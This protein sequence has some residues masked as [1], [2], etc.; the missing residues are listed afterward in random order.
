MRALRAFWMRLRGFFGSSRRAA[1]IAAELESHLQFHIEDNLRAGMSPEEARRQAIIRLGG[2]EQ[3]AQSCRERSTLPWLETV[4]QDLRFAVRQLK[5][6]PGFTLVVIVTL[7][8][9]IGVNTALFSIVNTVLLHPISLPHPAELVAVDASKPN[10]PYGSISWPNFRDWSRDNRSFS[11]L[12]IYKHAGFVL[13]GAGEAERIHGE[14]VSSDLF[15]LLGVRPTLG[16]L[17]APGEDEI[18]RGPLVLIGEGFWAR[19]F[20]SRA[21]IL[22]HA[23][24]LDG[25]TFTIIGVIPAAFDLSFRTFEAEDVYLPVGQWQ[26]K[27]LNDR[28]AGL[29]IH[30][31]ARLRPGV[32]L[33]RAQE[34]MNA[35][36]SQLAA[37]YPEDDRDIR[38][39]LTPLRQ[40]VVGDVQP[41]LLVLLG[42]VGFVLLIACVNVANLLLA[43][44]TARAQ[45][46]AVRMALG[47]RRS[48]MIRQLLTESLLLALAGG[49]LGLL[50][51]ASGTQA[52]LRL[53]PSALPHSSQIHLSPIV[54]GF[55]FF[56]S[57][58]V[59]IFFGLM[60]AWRVSAQQPQITLR[61]GARGTFG[62]H[63]RAQDWLVIFEIAAALVLLA[64][65][66]LMIRS[67]LALSHSDPGFER[68]GVLD[69]S[70][71]VP[72]SPAT[73]TPEAA[74]AYYR[75]VDRQIER[76]PGVF[77][78]SICWDAVP[79]TGDDDE[80]LFWLPNEVKPSSSMEMHWALR[81]VVEPDYLSVMRIPLLRGRFFTEADREGGPAVAVIDEDLAH[82]YFG[83]ANPIGQVLNLDDEQKPRVT[84]VGVVRHIMQWEL[85]DDAGF[86][87]RAQIYMPL[88][89]E[90]GWH[91]VSSTGM[92]T[93]I[94]VRAK[95]AA[96]I[97][98]AIQSALRRMNA[99]QVPYGAQTMNQ[100]IAATLSARRFSMILLGIFAGLA[101]LLA[102]VGLYGV[103]SYLVGQRRQEIAVRMALGADRN[104][105]LLWVVGRGARLSAIGSLAGLAAAL[106]LTRLMATASMLSGSM[107]Y[108]V[109]SWDPLTMSGVLVLL[110]TIALLACWLPARRAASVDPMQALRSE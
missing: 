50:V 36:S 26:T 22:G 75:E 21:D 7:A 30:G 81:Y 69:F 101:L 64:G 89:Q 70:L 43:R 93:D 61:E 13:T 88:A 29:G 72:Y 5:K 63:R 76:V 39:N 47:A 103:I 8:L 97:F 31:V 85:N 94:L 27:A 106:L 25:R 58:A 9:G 82:K 52:A 23:L 104:Q 65:A 90:P 86:P 3:T 107:I 67:L 62:T 40:S 10:F 4:G 60:P 80:Q 100:L 16:R 56:V 37:L 11:G 96:A 46:F 83:N 92:A 99:G 45:E 98:P 71:A 108:G 55:S 105:V 51:A 77:S 78:A 12:A 49:M 109:R 91:L 18:G 102:G 35:V 33:A 6:S 110:M 57:C 68:N 84:I 1:E 66:G 44:S 87:L 15:P 48:R 73:A 28:G 19:K 54:L 14:Y 42:A 53:A 32:T 2:M 74:R 24:T 41:I 95:D 34:D 20:G 38:A 59:G 79:M 17:F